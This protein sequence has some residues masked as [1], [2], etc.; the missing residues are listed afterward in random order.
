MHQTRI[1][2]LG[3]NFNSAVSCVG[4]FY[5]YGVCERFGV[6]L[7]VGYRSVSYSIVH[8]VLA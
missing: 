7:P 6:C 5:E 1:T 2:A 3:G 8:V 4:A